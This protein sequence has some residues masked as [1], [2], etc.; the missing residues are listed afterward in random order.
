MKTYSKS[1]FLTMVI[2]FLLIFLAGC[3][4]GTTPASPKGVISGRVM[5]PSS[6]TAKDITGWVPAA[7]ATVTLTDSEGVTH[8]VTTDEDGYY[9]FANVAVNTDTIITATATIDGN[10]V[11]MKDVVSQAVAAIEDY[12]AGTMNVE[13]TALG[14]IVEELIEQGLTSEDINLEEIQAS[15]NF[16]TVVEQVS[17][18]LEENGNVTTDPDVTEAVN[19]TAEEIIN[20]PAPEP[21][22]TPPAPAATPITEIAAITG[23]AKVGQVLTAGTLT[24]TAATATYQWQISDTSDGTYADIADATSSTY[25]PVTGDATKFIKVQATGTGNYTGTITSDATN[26]VTAATLESIAITTPATKLS[27]N[28]GDSLDITDL[29]VTGTYSDTTT[30]VETITTGNVTGFD[31]S[32]PAVDQVL[33]ITVGGKTTTYTVTIVATPITAIA[34]ITGTAQVG[35]V[36]TAG[37][38]TPSGATATYQWQICATSDGTYADIADATSSTYTPV[39]DDA[40]KFI[41]VKATGTGNY[42]GTVTSNPTGAVAATAVAFSN[43]TANGTSGTVT[44]TE[45]TLTFDIDPTSLAVGDITVTGATKGTLSGTGTTRTLAISNITVVNGADV[46]V[47]IADPAG[48]AITPASKTVAVNVKVYALCETG[49]AGGLIFYVKEGGYSDGWMYLEAA[50]SD[51]SASTEWGCEGVSIPGAD[52]TAVGTGEQNT[53]DIEAECTTDG[54]AAD[55]CANLSLGGYSDWFLPSKDELN[56]M[57]TNLKVAG[58]GGF[59]G[60]YYWS[61]SEYSATYAWRQYFG[62]GTSD[63]GTKDY[64]RWVRAV[65]AF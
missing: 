37:A 56:L 8:T 47:A 16:S 13:S 21:E 12:N 59:N 41:K 29:V 44:T 31:S 51:Q 2:F 43:L 57:Y 28:I 39:A 52:G 60:N 15:D 55:I 64:D 50:P 35:Q 48:F 46:T 53:I 20:P 19:D 3:L 65:R 33:T 14:L 1:I 30:K 40:N 4:P 62:C 45:L 54:T 5:V 27:Y 18:I 7:N 23:T 10:T 32:A 34:A 24:P 22:P 9:I 11:V 17:S 36:L 61:S 49:P 58:F 42:S 6:E 26:A 25:T 38:L 63:D